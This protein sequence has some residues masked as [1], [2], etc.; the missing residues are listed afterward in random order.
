MNAAALL[1]TLEWAVPVVLGVV[2]HEMAHGFVALR[3]G[4]TTARDARRL[5]LNPLRHVDPVGTVLFP[6]VLVLSRSPFVFGWA[7][8]VPV[9]FSR[10]KN[11]KRDMVWVAL[12]G[13][14]MNFV[15]A[16]AALAALGVMQNAAFSAAPVVIRMLLNAVLFNFSLMTFNLIP[17]LPLDGGRI[18][19]GILP[20]RQAIRFARTEK[21]GFGI[22]A[23]LLIFLPLLGDYT[24]RDFA[25]VS[26]FLAFSVQKLTYFF[27]GLFGL[28]QGEK[29]M[30]IGFFQLLVILL[31]VLVLF[32]RGKL[33][34]LAEDL[35]KSVSSFK[36]GLNEDKEPESKPAENDS[37]KDA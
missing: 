20:M 28:I 18:L 3:F 4:D 30:S 10:L 2:L 17:V 31:I 21:Y 29:G 34:A 25:F 8:P 7:K 5:T 15:L 35:G 12:A 24:G 27:A 19:T 32:G 26:R 37:S 33:P 36:K 9:D 22:I 14:A 6:L 16:L 13:P 11:P 1:S 23:L